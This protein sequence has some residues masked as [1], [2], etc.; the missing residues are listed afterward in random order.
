M[1]VACAAAWASGHERRLREGTIR[2]WGASAVST[3]DEGEAEDWTYTTPFGGALREGLHASGGGGVT[4]G[5]RAVDERIDRA[6][7][8]QLDPILFYDELILYESE[9]DDNGSM[10]LTV[11]VRR[12]RQRDA[13]RALSAQAAGSRNALLLV[14]P[15]PLLA[16]RGRRRAAVRPNCSSL[17]KEWR[18]FAIRRLRE[19][20]I[21]CSTS[22]A[23]A[24]AGGASLLRERSFREETFEGLRARGAPA[25]LAQY[26]DAETASQV[27]LAAGGPVTVAYDRL[28]IHGPPVGAV[29]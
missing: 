5:W 4:S 18:D 22:D 28:D 10:S 13:A 12:T 17:S 29:A 1:Q 11:K 6:Q 2:G 9:L 14:C 25:S 7:L 8:L 26:P 27:L 21:F 3:V 23:A 24:R 19:T 20:R 16:P 15:S